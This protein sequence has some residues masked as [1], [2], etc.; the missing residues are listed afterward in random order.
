MSP[1]AEQ[2]R[3]HGHGPDIESVAA[4]TVVRTLQFYRRCV[5][6]HRIAI[7]LAAI[8]VIIALVVVLSMQARGRARQAA[9]FAALQKAESVE[10]LTDIAREY[11]GNQPGMHAALEAARRLYETGKYEQ[12]ADRF[13]VFRSDFPDSDLIDAARLGEAY[14]LEAAGKQPQAEDR[15][16][17]FAAETLQDNLRLD[18]YLGAARNAMAQD[19][20]AEA[21]NWIE[22]AE[23]NADE[24]SQ[25][26]RI[27]AALEQLQRRRNTPIQAPA[28]P[29]DADAEAAGTETPE[30]T[31]SPESP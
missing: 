7:L 9:G 16:S 23:A 3:G 14:A 21:K 18:A 26:E 28:T 11:K 30:S 13:A 10:S 6:P 24:P 12:A 29:A 4:S 25:D 2:P 31:D 19:K 15:F 8:A 5:Q 1:K 27:N 17:T 20:L 22:K